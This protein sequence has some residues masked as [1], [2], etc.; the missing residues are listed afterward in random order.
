[1]A[2]NLALLE[3]TEP[4]RQRLELRHP[5]IREAQSAMVVAASPAVLSAVEAFARQAA[6]EEEHRERLLH[7]MVE[8]VGT[9]VLDEPR[10][11]QLQRQARARHDFLSEFPALSSQQVA[12]LSGS[13]ATNVAAL[14]SRWKAAGKVFAVSEG[15]ADRYPAF[16]FGDDGK[17]LP[18]IEKVIRALA[19]WSTW[20]I[21]LWFASNS[22]WLGGRRPVDLLLDSPDEVVDA[23][24]RS[25][26][27]LEF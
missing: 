15:R 4:E 20:A 1:M 5:E 18:V 12:E 23:A 22:G 14:A 10:V 9:A 6:W 17:P 16:Q 3:L 8:N 19:G 26:E 11:V 27:P 21:A 2:G 7:V 24:R 13:K 25:A